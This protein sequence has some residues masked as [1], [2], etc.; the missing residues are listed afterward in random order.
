MSTE[1][2]PCPFCGGDCEI[3]RMGT[4]RVSM[5]Y[6]C[7]EC[8]CSL[9]TSETFIGPRCSWNNRSLWPM[10]I[11]RKNESTTNNQ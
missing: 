5:I 8:G 4:P 3:E 11:E 9:E 2:K 6:Q 10:N 1:L 7:T